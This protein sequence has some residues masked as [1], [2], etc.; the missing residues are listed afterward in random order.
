MR[1]QLNRSL[2]MCA[3]RIVGLELWSRSIPASSM[4]IIPLEEHPPTRLRWRR[5]R[6]FCPHEHC[7]IK[8]WTMEDHRISAIGCVLT[9]RA[10]KWAIKQVGV[11]LSLCQADR[12]I[13]ER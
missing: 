10:A 3:V 1:S 12:A 6:M 11:S 7:S 2:E 9:T 5:H 8:T 4:Y 13:F